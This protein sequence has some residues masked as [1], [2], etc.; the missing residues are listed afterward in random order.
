MAKPEMLAEDAPG[1][2]KAPE[3]IEGTITLAELNR[4]AQ[5]YAD[6]PGSADR[7]SHVVA[8]LV[9]SPADSGID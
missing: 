1:T 9:R 8:R 6:V 3:F 7:D 5:A 2:Q 4:W